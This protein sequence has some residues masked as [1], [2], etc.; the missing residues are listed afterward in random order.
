VEE[1]RGAMRKGD[2]HAMDQA[3]RRQ[4]GFTL[5]EVMLVV[6]IIGIISSIAIPYYSRASARAYR[7]EMLVTMSKL[8]L[9][10]KNLYENQ[11]N[12]A[13]PAVVANPDV[14]PDPANTV[15]VGQ[16]VDWQPVQGHG[17][18]DIPFP[19]QGN[20][21]MRYL[22]KVD[23]TSTPPQVTLSACGV[24]PGFG[25]PSI[26]FGSSGAKCN[27]LYSEVMQGTTI[28]PAHGVAE[29]PINSFE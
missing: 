28:D 21:R 19:P 3:R 8:E 18:D 27:Y 25:S 17:W 10:F 22:Y 2:N 11:G 15:A 7:S 16:G 24:F 12:Y 20:I 9:Y 14:M 26:A 23:N 4:R 5:I 13:G 6:V 1:L 29:N